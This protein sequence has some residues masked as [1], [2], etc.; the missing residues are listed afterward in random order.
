M[1]FAVRLGTSE[2][3]ALPVPRPNLRTLWAT[4]SARRHALPRRPPEPGDSLGLARS[5]ATP[6]TDA[7]VWSAVRFLGAD[8]NIL[9]LDADVKLFCSVLVAI[10][11]TDATLTPS[12]PDHNLSQQHRGRTVVR[13]LSFSAEFGVAA[14]E[15]SDRATLLVDVDDIASRL[16]WQTWHGSHFAQQRIEESG[17]DRCA[18]VADRHPEATRSP[19]KILVV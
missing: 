8:H 4:P 19:L 2:P 15:Q 1:P 12:L 10:W 6:N 13:P 7:F 5:F 11:L 18:Y 17:P 16:R 14:L 9:K 3:S